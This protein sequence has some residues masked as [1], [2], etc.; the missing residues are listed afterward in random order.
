[1]EVQS[2]VN[3]A[4]A[5]KR[6]RDVKENI[7]AEGIEVARREH[8]GR[9]TEWAIDP[10]SKQKRNVRTLLTTMHK[11]LWQPNKWKE[12]GLA[13]VIQGSQVKMKYRKAMLVVRILFY[14]LPSFLFLLRMV[15][16]SLS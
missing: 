12:V 2:N 6:E 3:A 9:L 4:L 5:E 13:D 10:S 8:D 7:E 16:L 15:F 1:M 11:V 14:A